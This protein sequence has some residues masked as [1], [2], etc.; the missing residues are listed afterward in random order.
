MVSFIQQAC[1]RFSRH[2]T[3]RNNQFKPEKGFMC[4]LKRYV[5]FGN[6]ISPA[7]SSF[8]FSQIGTY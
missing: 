3:C 7:L 8:C 6:E 1:D 4:F 2:D 5:D